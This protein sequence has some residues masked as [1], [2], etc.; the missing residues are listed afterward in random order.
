MAATLAST[1]NAFSGSVT[2]PVREAFVDWAR[3]T[4]VNEI[5]RRAASTGTLRISEISTRSW[6]RGYSGVDRWSIPIEVTC[7]S[8]KRV[9]LMFQSQ[10]R[11][12]RRGLLGYWFNLKIILIH[13]DASARRV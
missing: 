2:R 5:R 9:M 3:R 11:L 12:S 13:A 7:P 4:D 1:I 8:P 10:S 6:K